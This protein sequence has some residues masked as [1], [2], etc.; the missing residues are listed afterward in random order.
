MSD[1]N[2]YGNVLNG[3]AS[4]TGSQPIS[5]AFTTPKGKFWEFWEL[6]IFPR[7][8]RDRREVIRLPRGV[9]ERADLQEIARTIWKG[10]LKEYLLHHKVKIE[11][12]SRE[13][14]V[15]R[16]DARYILPMEVVLHR[17]PALMKYTN[18][19]QKTGKLK[20]NLQARCEELLKNVP[21]FD[22]GWVPDIRFER[23]L[24]LGEREIRLQVG[25]VPETI[26]LLRWIDPGTN[27][28][29]EELSLKSSEET[30]LVG[31]SWR[32]MNLLVPGLADPHFAIEHRQEFTLVS[33]Q[34]KVH[35][36]RGNLLIP[37]GQG[38]SPLEDGDRI[39][40]WHDHGSVAFEFRTVQ[41]E[42]DC[43]GE[44]RP[45]FLRELEQRAK[46]ERSTKI[47][48]ESRS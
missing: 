22:P 36:K 17:G 10:G 25:P 8:S 29:M 1:P 41:Q 48:K 15:I 6:F 16:P 34:G 33:G 13:A 23:D 4:S 35:I 42:T 12:E 32:S 18:T 39:I 7:R 44:C 31:G 24:T 11:E 47:G 21:L 19:P 46:E 45:S 28:L 20:G 3:A 14:D 9:L 27:L 5:H 43:P 38:G 30:I 40:A 26:A 2:F 37:V